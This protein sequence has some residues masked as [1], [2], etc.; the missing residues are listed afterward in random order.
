[1]RRSSFWLALLAVLL[2]SAVPA[3]A[4]PINYPA[5]SLLLL[6]IGLVGLRVWR[7]RWQ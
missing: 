1:M 5:S 6:C 3:Y 4:G 7:K 2:L